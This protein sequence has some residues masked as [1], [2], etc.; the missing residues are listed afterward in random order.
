MFGELAATRLIRA[1]GR[2]DESGE[3]CMSRWLDSTTSEAQLV[4]DESAAVY[5]LIEP[6]AS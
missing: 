3:R 4:S 1:I 6:D 2:S 5:L